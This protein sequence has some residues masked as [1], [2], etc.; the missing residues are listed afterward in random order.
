MPFLVRKT[1]TLLSLINSESLIEALY[2]RERE[3]L[4]KFIKLQKQYCICITAL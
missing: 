3:N 1:T 4:T 2:S